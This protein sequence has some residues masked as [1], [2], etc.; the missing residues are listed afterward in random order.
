MSR[1]FGIDLGTTNSLI[2]YVKDGI[3]AVIANENGEKLVPSV[4]S[5]ESDETVVVGSAAKERRVQNIARTVYSIKRLMGKGVH[6]IAEERKML[7]FNL[8]ESSG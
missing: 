8:S 2:A 1:L 4:V 3:P 7:P 5:F 6:D